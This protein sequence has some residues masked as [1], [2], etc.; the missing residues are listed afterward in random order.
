MS[1][2]AASADPVGFERE[3]MRLLGNS[4]HCGVVAWLLGHLFFNLGVLRSPP[5]LSVIA[6]VVPVP[7]S[8]CSDNSLELRLV[9]HLNRRQTHR[10]A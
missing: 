2:A 5:S 4:F 3:Q 9:Q 8:P 1:S 6:P 10:G 7:P